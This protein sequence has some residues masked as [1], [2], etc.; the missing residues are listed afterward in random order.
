M[1]RGATIDGRRLE[2]VQGDITHERVDAIVNAANS[3]LAGGGGVDG[4]IHR[5]G[6]PAIMAQCDSIR[7][8]RGGCP[9]GE[10]VVTTAGKLA[11]RYVI[12]T[13][14]PVWRGGERGEPDLLARCYT[15]SLHLAD[16]HGC[17]S[18]AFPSIS[19]GVYRFPIEKAARI[20]LRTVLNELPERGI[21]LVRFV[22]FSKSDLETYVAALEEILAET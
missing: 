13:V 2:L 9:T 19:T 12:H 1:P 16:E 21:E 20:A 5:A 7:E 4:A 22:L 11:A 3:R 17:R 15:N 6:G 8:E 10:A 14:G 18:I